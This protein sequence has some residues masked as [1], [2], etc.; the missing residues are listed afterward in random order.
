MMNNLKKGIST[1]KNAKSKYQKIKE[2]GVS[3]Y[4]KDKMTQA[5]KKLAGK[6]LK[7]GGKL[8]LKGFNIVL[9]W[10]MTPVLGWVVSGILIVI[11]LFIVKNVKF[12]AEP[13]TIS[14]S[15]GYRSS[16]K[17]AGKAELSDNKIVAVLADCR[18]DESKSSDDSSSEGGGKVDTTDNLWLQKI[19]GDTTVAD[20]IKKFLTEQGFSGPQ[21]AILLAV[22]ARESGLDPK[23]DNPSG[24]VHGVWQ[25]SN[26]GINKDRMKWLRDRGGDINSLDDQFTLLKH[27][28]STSYYNPIIQVF[29]KHPGSSSEDME[30]NLEIWESLFEGLL[31]GDGQRNTGTVKQYIEGVFK[32]YPGLKDQ[33]QGSNFL[34][35]FNV[36]STDESKTS[37]NVSSSS[38]D[39]CGDDDSSGTEAD[40]TGEVPSDATAWGYKPDDVPDSLKKFIHNPSDVGLKYGG[41]NGWVEHSGQCVDLTESLGNIIWGNSGIT[42]GNGI[43]QADAWASRV[44]KNKVKDK[45]KA[46]AIFSTG[47]SQPGHTGIVSHVFEN[48]D[49]LVIEQNTPLSG[50]DYFHVPDTWDYRIFRKDE[51]KAN[52][53]KFAYP[54]DRDAD[55]SKK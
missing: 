2:R 8:A 31:A 32:H 4:A 24:G 47:F 54:D 39:D 15:N 38:D 33:G 10:L 7:A 27:E 23:A 50:S 51:Q 19:G 3:G 22:G 55:W 49:V 52:N 37:G 12:N 44:F 11:S 36:T 45:P 21:I 28:L 14:Q 9:K 1:A 40:W 6:G 35:N 29:A 17:I 25:W 42:Q 13:D 46:G 41:P 16:Q 30:A 20:K 5:S 34:N 43:D 26:G 48:G 18:H 53:M